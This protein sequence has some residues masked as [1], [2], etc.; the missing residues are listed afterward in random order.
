[1]SDGQIGC[2]KHK[3]TTQQQQKTNMLHVD[4]ENFVF[5]KKSCRFK[6]PDTCGQGLK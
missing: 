6:D 5:A 4:V 1:M 2:C 3:K